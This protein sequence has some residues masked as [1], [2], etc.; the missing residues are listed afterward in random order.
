[1]PGRFANTIPTTLSPQ[2]VLYPNSTYANFPHLPLFLPYKSAQSLTDLAE[3]CCA[4][5]MKEISVEPRAN[6]RDS[7]VP[8]W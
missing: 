2:A 4:N 7:F 5:L 8:G 1:M 6:G 3:G